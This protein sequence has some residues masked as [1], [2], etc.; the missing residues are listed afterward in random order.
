MLNCSYDYG[1]TFWK[2]K[3]GLFTCK[4]G[5]SN[6]SFN[7]ETIKSLHIDSD[8]EEAELD[9]CIKQM[10]TDKVKLCNN[11]LSNQDMGT[12]K[13]NSNSLNHK[14]R[15]SKNNNLFE[16]KNNFKEP[17]VNK[18]KPKNGLL[19]K[20]KSINLNVEKDKEGNM[21]I[22]KQLFK[23]ADRHST[24]VLGSKLIKN[25]PQSVLDI[26]NKELVDKMVVKESQLLVNRKKLSIDT[27]KKN[28]ICNNSK[29]ISELVKLSN[30]KAVTTYVLRPKTFSKH[31][32]PSICKNKRVV[33]ISS[34]TSSLNQKKTQEDPIDQIIEFIKDEPIYDDSETELN[35]INGKHQSVDSVETQ[36]SSVSEALDVKQ[37][38]KIEI[39]RFP[40]SDQDSWAS[41]ESFNEI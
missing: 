29:V 8:N 41:N 10:K 24:K 12:N 28:N 37:E 4:C 34:D 9:G 16:Q 26:L 35:L 20:N 2:I 17:I 30:N 18:S 38:P 39:H 21:N 23:K 5:K 15:I 36:Y 14:T 1:T 22:P 3:G 27:L 33:D 31:S 19:I 7:E 6:C 40:P 32:T 25:K 13:L 11:E